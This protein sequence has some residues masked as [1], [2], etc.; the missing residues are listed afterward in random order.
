MVNRV[1]KL[2]VCNTFKKKKHF[3]QHLTLSLGSLNFRFLQDTKHSVWWFKDKQ[4]NSHSLCG[5][6][7]KPASVE[8]KALKYNFVC[9][10]AFAEVII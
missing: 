8:S 6:Q 7:E 9:V 1:Y 2:D 5:D 10:S 4:E 3:Q